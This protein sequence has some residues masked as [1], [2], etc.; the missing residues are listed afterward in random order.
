MDPQ[1]ADAVDLRAYIGVL[2]QRM[3]LVGSVVLVVL[4]VTVAFSFTRTPV[5]NAEALVLIKAPPS[6]AT[7][8][9]PINLET[10][11]QVATSEELA[12]IVEQELATDMSADDLIDSLTVRQVPGT[13]VLEFELAVDEPDLAQDGANAFAQAYVAYRND[14]VSAA[15][16]RAEDLL[17]TRLNS[18]QRQLNDV[19]D[20]ITTS[21]GAERDAL[22]ER[23]AAILVRIGLLEQRLAD[24][25]PESTAELSA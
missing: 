17:T 23:R 1:R 4:L 5:Y 13:E 14:Q 11:R 7:N 2:R 20:A 15:L 25:Q 3:R 8:V 9:P 24:L 10:E 12:L 19:N 18:A 16:G 22:L 6:T 21:S